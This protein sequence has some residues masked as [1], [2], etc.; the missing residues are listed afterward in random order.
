MK[1]EQGP[2]CVY[3]GVGVGMCVCQGVW[4]AILNR[5]VGKDPTHVAHLRKVLKEVREQPHIC[6]W[7]EF[8]KQ[9]NQ[10]VQGF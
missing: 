1:Q 10:E 3:I 5:M 9:R 4:V 8:S 6:L 7:K 2:Q